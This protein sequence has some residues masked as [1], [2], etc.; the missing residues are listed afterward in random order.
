ME[1][2]G[3]IQEVE[4]NIELVRS[5]KDSRVREVRNAVELLISK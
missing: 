1:L 4:K 2:I 5:A 3:L